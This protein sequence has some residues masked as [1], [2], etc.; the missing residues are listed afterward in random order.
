MPSDSFSSGRYASIKSCT[1]VTKD[2][3]ITINAGIRTLF[4]ITLRIK[5]I[6]RLDIAKTAVCPLARIMRKECARRGYRGVTA[7]WSDE[8]AL[9]PQL[10]DAEKQELPEGRRAMPGSISFVPSVAGLLLAG[11]VVKDLIAE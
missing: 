10:S 9:T 7:L 4:G 11:E 2:A 5:E 6:N 8:D 1:I 3:T